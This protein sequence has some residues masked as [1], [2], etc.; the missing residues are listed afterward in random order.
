MYM[1]ILLSTLNDVKK[2][3]RTKKD[4]ILGYHKDIYQENCALERVTI[5]CSQCKQEN[6]M[7]M[8][9]ECA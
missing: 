3:L 1:Y 6:L 9:G 2:C 7:I 5:W 4:Q 8:K